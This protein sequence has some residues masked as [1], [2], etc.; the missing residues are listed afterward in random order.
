MTKHPEQQYLDLMQ[1][2]LDE[3]DPRMD[4]T[5][6]GTK[7]LFGTQMRFN[8]ADGFPLLSTKRVYWK[9]AFKEM[10]LMLNGKTDL[11][12]YLKQNV[13]IWTDWPLKK[14]RDATGHQI[15]L[16]DFEKK[17]LED[18]DFAAKYQSL[19]RFYGA[20][21]TSWRTTDGRE[22]NQIK[23]VIDTLRSNPTSRRIIVEG[24]NVGELDNMALPPCH[25]TYQFFVN[26]EKKTLS[27]ALSCRST[28]AF[29]GLPFNLANL[30]LFL[31][32]VA[33]QTGFTPGEAIWYGM[34]THLYLNHLDAVT[35]QIGRTPRPLP[36][37]II[38]RK[39]ASIFDYTIDDLEIV[40]YDPHPAI[41][42]EVAV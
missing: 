18:D 42:A 23:E 12:D 29:L 32:L 40:G 27:L 14:Y 24:W 41:K 39:A 4:R 15:S 34:D 20:Q 30:C 38:K 25:K 37:L 28:D 21:W 17:I 16:E 22:I 19:G 6:V 26:V 2:I 3:G 9:T 36:K 1:R 5:G 7:A 11:R 13:H 33:D 31:H 8:M 10:L 35:E